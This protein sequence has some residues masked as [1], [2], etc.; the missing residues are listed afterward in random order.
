MKWFKN[1]DNKGL[2]KFLQF[3]INDFYPSIKEAFLNEATLSGKKKPG[4]KLTGLNC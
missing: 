3:D 2:Y 1:I 4:I